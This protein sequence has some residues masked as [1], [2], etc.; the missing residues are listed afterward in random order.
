LSLAHEEARD[1]ALSV[2]SVLLSVVASLGALLLAVAAQDFRRFATA[3][4]LTRRAGCARLSRAP[5]RGHAA[6]ATCLAAVVTAHAVATGAVARNAGT[7]LV[8]DLNPPNH[9]AGGGQNRNQED[10]T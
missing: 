6:G 10:S 8:T 9:L 2:L 5:T 7:I 1:V 4:P 3:R